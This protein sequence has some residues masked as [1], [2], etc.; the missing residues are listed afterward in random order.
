MSRGSGRGEGR[1]NERY[2]PMCWIIGAAA[3][4]VAVWR[5]HAEEPI[6]LR[7]SQDGVYERGEYVVDSAVLVDSGTTMTL[8]PG[9]VLRFGKY[10]EFS[11]RGT[12]RARGTATDMIVFTSARHRPGTGGGEEPA[13]FDWNGI[14]LHGERGRIELEYA[15]ISY[16]TIGI[17]APLQRNV[18]LENSY[19]HDNGTA[20]LMVNNSVVEFPPREPVQ[21]PPATPALPVEEEAL[22]GPVSDVE[23]IPSP[24]QPSW[25]QP[26]RIG[27]I[28]LAVLGLGLSAVGGTTYLIMDRKYN[29]T[30]DTPQANAHERKGDT[31]AMLLNVGLPVLAL[32]LAAVGVTILF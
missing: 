31:A 8:A 18:S 14:V 4:L 32:G 25:E 17:K 12:L 30:D 29:D 3:L 6:F 15:R 9:T 27:G 13:P 11:V 24:P 2:K 5:P 20:D 7:G 22:A 19:F 21:Y 1:M 10:G 16:A 28:G 23:A 26:T